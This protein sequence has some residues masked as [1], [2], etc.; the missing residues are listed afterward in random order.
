MFAVRP[1]LSNLSY[2]HYMLPAPPPEAGGDRGGHPVL[3]LEL[4]GD[5]PAPG[6]H[7]RRADHPFYG[8]WIRSYAGEDYQRTNDALVAL[9][10]QLAEGSTEAEYRRLEEIFVTCS[11]MSWASGK[12]PGRWSGEP[13]PCWN[14][15]M[16]P[17]ST[18]V[19][20]STSS[21]T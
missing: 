1:A 4:R 5:R 9:M 11:G 2:T 19:R 3:L 13:W 8:E 7:S 10:D 16:S 17:T 21:T 14:F 18:P 15:R 20:T 6:R 12:W